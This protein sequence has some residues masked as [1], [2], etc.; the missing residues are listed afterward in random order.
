MIVRHRVVGDYKVNA[1]LVACTETGKAVIIDPGGDAAE[2][3]AMVAAE[4]ATPVYILN[5]HGHADHV[6]ANRELRQDF[7]VPVC[8]HE[9]DVRLF[10]RGEVREKSAREL[11]LPAPDGADILLRDGQVL[12]VGRLRIQVLHTPGHTP[13]SVCYLVAGNL[14]TGDTLFVGDVGRTDLVGGSLEVLIQSLA[15]LIRL[16][17]ETVVRPGHDYGETPT[18]TIGRERRENPYITDFLPG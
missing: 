11:G 10:A 7:A 1:Y 12:E 18:S 2:I 13:G 8:M 17:E 5:T 3:R 9:D 14:F 6:L 15:R 4:A 16:P